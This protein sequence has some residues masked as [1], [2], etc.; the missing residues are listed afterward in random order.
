MFRVAEIKADVGFRVADAVCRTGFVTGRA[1][2]DVFIADHLVGS[3]TLKT[4]FV[5][6]GANR[7]GHSDA[8][9]FMTR[10]AIRLTDV[11]GVVEMRAKTLHR[12]ERF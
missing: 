1:R 2:T 11:L 3:M 12:R 9:G 6:G 10:R 8:F 7:N 5:R 4:R